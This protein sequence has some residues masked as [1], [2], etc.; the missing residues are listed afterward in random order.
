LLFGSTS[1]ADSSTSKSL[2][3]INTLTIVLEGAPPAGGG[4]GNELVQEAEAAQALAL[5]LALGPVPVRALVQGAVQEMALALVLA[6]GPVQGAVQ[7][8]RTVSAAW[9]AQMAV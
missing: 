9:R 8:R 7:H 2:K 4:S 5:A 3:Y 1:T 6:L